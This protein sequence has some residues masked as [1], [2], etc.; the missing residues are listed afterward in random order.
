M[1]LPLRKTAQSRDLEQ[2]E[3]EMC[4]VD[5][6]NG[7]VTPH[8]DHLTQGRTLVAPSWCSE[9]DRRTLGL[10]KER[11]WRRTI[12]HVLGLQAGLGPFQLQLES[13]VG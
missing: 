3:G 4:A 13:F 7:R 1:N 2:A 9:K 11:Q 8:A 5:K 6:L 12:L 10:A